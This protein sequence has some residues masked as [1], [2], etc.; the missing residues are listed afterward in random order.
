MKT[1]IFIIQLLSVATIHNCFGAPSD[2]R[3]LE[4]QLFNVQK[5]TNWVTLPKT[6]KE[7][8]V[9]D[10]YVTIHCHPVEREGVY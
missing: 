7:H 9:S 5:S 10:T 4:G 1:F 3:V 6:T 8:I 2:W